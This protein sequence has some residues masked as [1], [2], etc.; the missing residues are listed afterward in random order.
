MVA[1][2]KRDFPVETFDGNKSELFRQCLC[3]GYFTNVARRY[4]SLEHLSHSPLKIS[5][6]NISWRPC[7]SVGKVFCTMDGH[8]SMVHIH[9]SSSVNTFVYSTP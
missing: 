2:Q 5:E 1:F 6:L 3:T 4:G 9:P 8:G 7:R